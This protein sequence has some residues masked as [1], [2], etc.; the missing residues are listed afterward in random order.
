LSGT[1]IFLKNCSLFEIKL[2]S[3]GLRRKGAILLCP[4]GSRTSA[5]AGLTARKRTKAEAWHS[6]NQHRFP[7]RIGGR[8]GAEISAFLLSSNIEIRRAKKFSRG[9]LKK[10]F[11]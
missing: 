10:Y 2:E 5:S 3:S 1:S 6:K 8:R 11:C 9:L 7:C 4:Q